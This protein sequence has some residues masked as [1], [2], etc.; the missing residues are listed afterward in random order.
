MSA[1]FVP[2]PFFL[3][4]AKQ[5]RDMDEQTIESFGIEGLTLMEVAG[6]KA[7]DYILSIFPGVD[8]CRGLFICGKGNNAG[9]AL[10]AARIAHQYD[11]QITIVFIDGIE[12][13]SKSAC[14]N[15][16]L[17]EKL[18]K[19][20]PS[21]ITIHIDDNLENLQGTFNYIVDGVLGTGLNTQ[22]KGNY[23]STVQWINN[24]ASTVFSLDIPTGLNSDTG[25]E[26][27][28]AIYADY[29]LTFGAQKIGFLLEKGPEYVGKVILCDL[30]FPKHLRQ[31]NHFKIDRSWVQKVRIE[32][33]RKHKYDG[34]ILHIIAGSEGLTGAAVLAARSAWAAG[35]GAVNLITP[36]GLLDVYEKNLIEIIKKAV[37]SEQET[38]FTTQHLDSVHNILNEKP[39]VVLIGPGLGRTEETIDFARQFLSKYKGNVV[40]DADAIYALSTNEEIKKPDSATWILT[41]HPGELRNLSKSDFDKAV[42]RIQVAQETSIKINSTIVS[43]GTPTII[44]TPEGNTYIT[45]YQTDIFSRAG[46]GDVLAGKIAAFTLM[47][48][49][50]VIAICEALLDGKTKAD[51][52]ML[53]NPDSLPAPLDIL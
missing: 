9:D 6:V 2:H 26:M 16:E 34:G 35:V 17:I 31:A 42:D 25:M 36:K 50:H 11:H 51:S 52:Y 44:G 24:Q 41:P 29:T 13:L 37:G 32:K 33:K 48:E 23:L 45:G 21:R 1:Q 49:Q 10:V 30:P 28:A 8:T 22:L 7:A 20:D 53:Q 19:I 4:T 47:Q 5:C 15:L 27:G 12:R 43:K 18:Q 46:F 14:H 39:G 3:C 40:I 38:S